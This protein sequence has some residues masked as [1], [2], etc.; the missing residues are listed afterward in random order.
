MSLKISIIIPVHNEEEIIEKTIKSVIKTMKKHPY[1]I[2]VV[3][4]NSNDSTGK[5]LDSLCKKNRRIRV[6]HKTHLKSGPTGLGSALKTGFNL[7]TGEIIIPFMGD[8][9]DNPNDI[10]KFT[11][12][13]EDGY[14]VV[15]GS[16]FVSDSSLSD[17]PFIKLIVNRIYNNLFSLLFNLKIND[18]SNAFKA[19]RKKIIKTV[20]PI[21]DGFEITSEI[22]L[23]A[24]INGFKIGQIPVSWQESRVKRKSKFGSFSS[25]SFLFFKLPKIG[26]SYV[27]LSLIL[28]FEFLF[29]SITRFFKF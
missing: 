11:K 1:E 7:A 14:D 24:H 22:V 19:Y 10:I 8:M 6:I 9:S 3:D 15:C 4:D 17:Y 29:K 5:I 16:R 28:W 27:R 12:K 26:I 20:R 2:I 23:K 21:S 25:L 13:I 18:I